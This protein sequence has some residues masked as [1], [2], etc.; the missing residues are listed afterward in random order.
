M[1]KPF[2]GILCLCAVTCAGR[3]EQ[4]PEQ[5]WV[6]I[7]SEPGSRSDQS[8]AIAV[9]SFGNVYV[10]GVS[11]LETVATSDYVIIKYDPNGSQLWSA[12]Y[13]GTA[14]DWD[15]PKVIVVDS[16]GNVYVAGSS[17][18]IGSECDY[19]T[20]KYDTDGKELWVA[21][22]NGPTNGYDYLMDMAITNSG[23]V[24][25]T[26]YRSG[27][28]ST[29]KYDSNGS[30][31]WVASDEIEGRAL[32]IDDLE[33]VYVTGQYH[34]SGKGWNYITAKYE[35]NGNKLWS[36]TYVGPFGHGSSKDIVVDDQYN[37]YISGLSSNGVS[38]DYLTIKYDSNGNELWMARYNNGTDNI[39]YNIYLNIDNF[40]NA[41]VTG[42]SKNANNNYD[43][44]TIK[45]DSNGHELWARRYNGP[46]DKDDW[47]R[48]ATIDDTGNIYVTGASWDPNTSD[49]CVTIKYDPNGNELWNMRY[50]DSQNSWDQ[51][52][53]IEIDKSGNV[54]VTG[55][56]TN[57]SYDMTN[58]TI[59]YTQHDYC[60]GAIA[61][62]F[63]HN[64]KVDFFDFA[65]FAAAWLEGSNFE[66]LAVL[67]EHWLKCNFALEEDCW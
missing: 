62:D 3:A 43:Y 42:V 46:A 34:V 61:G 27:G 49:D 36:S 24:Y 60:T 20:L 15:I 41:I 12:R 33:N 26:G 13:N 50:N 17:Y 67:G 19:A 31:V 58:L 22:Y 4:P 66:N 63:D 59:K 53:A 16:I 7:Y 28:G 48:D 51:G 10:T 29:I 38:Y 65:I 9:D 8:S 35:P 32:A 6:A 52:S 1:R 64:C 18:G 47:P 57:N 45:Y 37:V 56:A 14:N 30:E 25:V 23:Y 40:N 55:Y 11:Y 5:Q 54:Y 39:N 2:L 44:L 21:R